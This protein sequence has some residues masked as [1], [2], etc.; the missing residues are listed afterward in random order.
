[1]YSTGGTQYFDVG[2]ISKLHKQRTRLELAT[3]SKRFIIHRR[4]APLSPTAAHFPR[5]LVDPRPDNGVRAPLRFFSDCRLPR[6]RAHHVPVTFLGIQCGS[7][8]CG[9]L[10]GFRGALFGF[11]GPLLCFRGPLLGAPRL[12]ARTPRRAF[13]IPQPQAAFPPPR[14]SPS[15]IGA[16]TPR[17]LI[18]EF[19]RWQK[20]KASRICSH[21]RGAARR[22][23]VG[24]DIGG[25]RSGSRSAVRRECAWRRTSPPAP[26]R[27]WRKVGAPS[28]PDPCLASLHRGLVCQAGRMGDWLPA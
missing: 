4:G 22:R 13:Q 21:Q 28:V 7:L 1:V 5:P 15:W 27:T 10:L 2:R 9:A 26:R 18:F 17:V 24:R 3:N 20:P 6:P 25:G 11:R 19:S 16:K 12:G 8:L 23:G 14:T